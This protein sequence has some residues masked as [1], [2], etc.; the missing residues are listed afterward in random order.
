M[1]DRNLAFNDEKYIENL[2][3]IGVPIVNEDGPSAA[4][5]ISGPAHRLSDDRV[6]RQPSRNGKLT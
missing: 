1:R 5:T 4:L 3:A 2:W 6:D